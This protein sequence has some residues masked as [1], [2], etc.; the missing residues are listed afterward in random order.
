MLYDMYFLRFKSYI[1]IRNFAYYYR[2][3]SSI[4]IPYNDINFYIA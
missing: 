4:L 3:I 1:F 2:D